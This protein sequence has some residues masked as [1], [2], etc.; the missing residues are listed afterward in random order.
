MKNVKIILAGVAVCATLFANA[1]IDALGGDS[2]FWPGDRDNN[3]G[4]PATINDHGYV[5][6][7]GVNWT[8]PNTTNGVNASILWGDATKWGFSWDNGD[9]DTWFNLAWGNGDMGLNVAYRSSTDES[10]SAADVSGFSVGYGQNFDWGELGVGFESNDDD[11]EYWVNWRGDLDA[12]V[13]ESAKVSFKMDEDDSGIVDVSN[14][15]LSFDLFTH[16]DAGGADVLFGF[17]VDYESHDV[18]TATWTEMTLPSA[19]VAVEAALTDWATLRAHVEH[20]YMFSCDNSDGV[21]NVCTDGDT[22]ANGG[23]T[24]G[25]GLGF[26]WG[27]VALDMQIDETLFT[28]PVSTITGQDHDASLASG[29]VTLSYT[30]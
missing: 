11:S 5:E 12:W 15:T 24:Y 19:I 21:L 22:N 26:D 3:S 13:F 23:T 25:F 2:G 29:S 14:T 4:F 27:Q 7:E 6:L 17:G 20:D 10:N 8:D 18:G 16:L 1:R 9:N 28:D 30:F